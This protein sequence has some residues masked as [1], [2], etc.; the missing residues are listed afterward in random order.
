MNR[1]W[2]RNSTFIQSEGLHNLHTQE[3]TRERETEIARETQRSGERMRSRAERCST[4][5]LEGNLTSNLMRRFP[6]RPGSL[7][8]G[9]PSLEMTSS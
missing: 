2:T 5:S 6:L 3:F 8:M 1:T 7:A 9:M 4:E